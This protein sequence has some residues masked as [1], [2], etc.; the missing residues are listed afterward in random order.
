[1]WTEGQGR[2]LLSVIFES[3][4]ERRTSQFSY[5]GVGTIMAN[6]GDTPPADTAVATNGSSALAIDILLGSVV[7][8]LPLD[9]VT[10]RS[11]IPDR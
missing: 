3:D 6:G 8:A 11:R 4:D 2:Q 1:V 7:K 9:L 10:N 5:A